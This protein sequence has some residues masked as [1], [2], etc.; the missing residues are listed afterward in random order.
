MTTTWDITDVQLRNKFAFNWNTLPKYVFQKADENWDNFEYMI[1]NLPVQTIINPVDYY[2]E[3]NKNAKR[4]LSLSPSEICIFYVFFNPQFR[5][6]VETQE[7]GLKRYKKTLNLTDDIADIVDQYWTEFQ[8]TITRA[9]LVQDINDQKKRFKDMYESVIHQ[10][11]ILNQAGFVPQSSFVSESVMRVYRLAE[12]VLVGNVY[13]LF[14]II[15]VSELFPL[16]TTP[17][18]YKVLKGFKYSLKYPTESD[19]LYMFHSKGHV[20]IRV[21]DN[22][23]EI[24]FT[25]QQGEDDKQFLLSIC[26]SFGVESLEYVSFYTE[27]LN[28]FA[29]FPNQTLT[30]S[31]WQDILVTHPT[32]SQQL[33]FDETDQKTPTTLAGVF[34]LEKNVHVPLRLS[35]GVEGIRIHMQ[36]AANMETV[37]H[38]INRISNYIAYYNRAAPDLAREYNKILESEVVEAEVSDNFLTTLSAISSGGGALS[39]TIAPP[40]SLSIQSTDC[41]FTP[42]IVNKEE[43]LKKLEDQESAIQ[44]PKEGDTSTSSGAQW[45]SCSHHSSHPF[46]GLKKNTYIMNKDEFPLIPCCFQTDQSKLQHSLYKDY[47][48]TKS[49]LQDFRTS[50]DKS[51]TE[52]KIRYLYHKGSPFIAEGQTG[53]CSRA[54]HDLYALTS[55]HF[56]PC[57]RGFSRSPISFLYCVLFHLDHDQFRSKSL[58]DQVEFASKE[59]KTSILNAS[60]E[61][62]N[63]CLQELWNIELPKQSLL[64]EDVYFNPRY[65]ATL[66]ESIYSCRIVLLGEDDFIYPNYAEG[67]VRWK[68]EDNVPVV[69]IFENLGE[70]SGEFPQCELVMLSHKEG[71]EIESKKIELLI[72]KNIYA[73]YL[74]CFSN[75]E[76]FTCYDAQIVR[77]LKEDYQVTAQH[78]DY[79][80]KVFAYNG[81]FNNEELTLFIADARLPPSNLPVTTK[82]YKSSKSA[83][84]SFRKNM[85]QVHQLRFYYLSVSASSSSLLVEYESKRI[86]TNLLVENAKRILAQKI[87]QYKNTSQEL[88]AGIHEN[89]IVVRQTPENEEGFQKFLFENKSELVVPNEETKRRLVFLLEIELKRHYD[90]ILKY[91][92]SPSNFIPYQYKSVSDFQEQDNCII[93]ERD[94]VVHWNK[95]IYNIKNIL[96]FNEIE[97]KKP[98]ICQIQLKFYLCHWVS[99]DSLRAPYTMLIPQTKQVFNVIAHGK[100][101]NTTPPCFVALKTIQHNLYILRAVL[102]V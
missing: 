86:Q 48:L 98:F 96:N 67:V 63:L 40:P 19:T 82:L 61:S 83:A 41:R 44:F 60:E 54:I 22:L 75:I 28:G 66:V 23:F 53:K 57:R 7:D 4:P 51:N 85:F 32:I 87:D 14:D 92:H 17:K 52:Q 91:A 59:F 90:E 93:A 45:F 31:L 99:M 36:N 43:D 16:V 20:E 95:G 47:Y 9:K 8:Q 24:A 11:N 49:S 65:F 102:F 89:F 21:L 18:F 5:F 35:Q 73:L 37:N 42:L 46:V 50:M 12:N 56:L 72:E 34:I 2:N 38:I 10:D 27:R 100:K 69:I 15:H 39:G 58:S 68:K 80:G 30:F 94:T 74:E 88:P 29:W 1:I 6:F 3:V 13:S 78:V 76:P 25:I 79:Y 55:E 97:L 26:K 70:Y 101:S 62:I 81:V 71:E 64:K 33:V 84:T 77:T